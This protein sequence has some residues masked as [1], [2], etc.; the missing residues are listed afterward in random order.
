MQ[1]DQAV[2]PV[3]IYNQA[4]DALNRGAWL[5]A[6]A[7]AEQVGKLVPDHAGVH[8]VAGV[9]ALELRQMAVAID[10]LQRAVKLNPAR[11]DYAA[12][13]A[14][15]LVTARFFREAQEMADIAMTM[16]PRDAMT[17][18]TLGVVYS[19]SNAYGRAIEVFRQVAALMPRR[20]SYRF[21]LAT[22][23]TY[24][25]EI[26][27]AEKEYEACLAID[28]RYWKAHL[29]LSQLRKQSSQHNHLSR[30]QALLHAHAG[31]AG[32]E[33]YAN[34]AL[35]KEFEDL[36]DYGRAFEH[37]VAGKSSHGKTRGYTSAKDAALF[38][39][40]MAAM[41]EPA[42][43][44]SGY[45]TREP[46]FVIGMPR[47]GT[48]LVERILSSHSSVH[49]AGELQ[50]FSVAL[51]YASGSTTN[52]MLD[53][54]TM[55]RS[56]HLDWAKLG[57]AYLESTRPAT[58]AKPHFV[59]KLPH[60]FLYAGFIAQALPSARII[61]LHRDPL[62]TCLSNFRQ[63]FALSS[64]YYD[65]SFD[66]LNTGRYYLLFDRLMKHWD[67]VIPGRILHLDYEALVQDQ[68]LNTRK[69]L[70]FCGLPWEDACLRFEH[71]SAPV[72]TASA[73]QVRDPINRSYMR[74]WERYR[75]QLQP[76]REL[77][78]AGGIDVPQ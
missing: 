71:N 55:R 12:Q 38:D 58:G 9:A 31:D 64:P 27:A 47:S 3:K 66:L 72:A 46:I 49:S 8:F 2:E 18:D 34:L 43:A 5:Q 24:N 10:R 23:L 30:L 17:L 20:A 33:L 61:C 45:A 4:I 41:P 48:T 6:Q 59:D 78:V 76:L 68:E 53:L 25:G 77:L 39:A 44:L 40:I 35:A 67:E 36:A 52:E 29:A 57:K 26:E 69:L 13:F 62:D 1:P 22:S 7:L 75:A 70:D 15:A 65:Y 74:R 37:L 50:N 63:L 16:G 42:T 73:V 51:K 21:N 56:S 60:N 14:R 11:P 19:Q 54:D 28:P 32:A